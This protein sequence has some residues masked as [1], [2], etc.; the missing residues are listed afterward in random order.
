MG[1]TPPGPPGPLGGTAGLTPAAFDRIEKRP[2]MSGRRFEVNGKR[3]VT[4]GRN[5]WRQ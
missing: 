4:S 5:L 1:A 3:P 2:G